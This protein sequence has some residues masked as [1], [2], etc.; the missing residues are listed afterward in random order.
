MGNPITN[1]QACSSEFADRREILSLLNTF[2][3]V[4][5]QEKRAWASN[6]HWKTLICEI[7]T[8]VTALQALSARQWGLHTYILSY[9]KS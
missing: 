9:C 7:Q 1:L 8:L 2:L 3:T 6:S 4:I 5:S